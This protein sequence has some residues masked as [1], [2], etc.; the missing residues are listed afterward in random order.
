VGDNL[1]HF[2]PLFL[3][4]AAAFSVPFVAFFASK[5]GLAGSMEAREF[6]KKL[7]AEFKRAA[8]ETGLSFSV[9]ESSEEIVLKGS[10]DGID[11]EVRVAQRLA[12]RSG[13][14]RLLARPEGLPVGIE[15]RWSFV[16]EAYETVIGDPHFDSMM[17]VEGALPD[18]YLALTTESR[19]A[20]LRSAVN[21]GFCVRE[22]RVEL[23]LTIADQNWL[24][25]N[26][27]SLIH[28]AKTLVINEPRA[29]R[30]LRNYEEESIP[31]IALRNA[32]VLL[33]EEAGAV[34]ARAV[35][36][37]ILNEG[38]Q[39]FASL[40]E[41]KDWPEVLSVVFMR[42]PEEALPLVE[43]F[44]E[45]ELHEETQIDQSGL[46]HLAVALGVLPGVRSRELLWRILHAGLGGELMALSSLARV[47]VVADV[48]PLLELRPTFFNRSFQGQI[49]ATVAT[50]QGRLD[51]AEGG[52]L[53]LTTPG[54]SE[55][56]LTLA[57]N[58][59]GL[60]E[61]GEGSGS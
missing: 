56:A 58:E 55:G 4:V 12:L 18:L 39:R 37:L 57:Q 61:T 46:D 54:E 5:F 30:W 40:H 15:L 25:K 14:G 60:S 16:T 24:R 43:A 45:T 8:R 52:R 47:G 7:S 38:G 32:A 20:I 19:A 31:L 26:L 51:G 35:T 1:E 3:A 23:D 53:A 49:D 22:G 36:E 9:D 27:G 42:R 10:V 59:G 21:D 34:E 33:R 50:I 11:V 28:A 29:A 44:L 2:L 13:V 41:T 48:E 17:S 6:R